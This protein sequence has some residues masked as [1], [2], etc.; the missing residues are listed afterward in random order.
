[1]L[2]KKFVLLKVNFMLLCFFE[3][4]FYIFV[5]DISLVL[6]S[7]RGFFVENEF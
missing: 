6:G 3:N 4:L 2:P 7:K 1:M 5:A